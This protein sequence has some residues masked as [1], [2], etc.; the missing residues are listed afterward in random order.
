MLYLIRK[1]A[2]RA[3]LLA[4]R[5]S[6]ANRVA[7]V[8]H[9]ISHLFQILICMHQHW[10][11]TPTSSAA[12]SNRSGKPTFWGRSEE[13]DVHT[14][15]LCDFG[16]AAIERHERQ[17][18]AFGEGNIDRILSRAA[19]A[20]RHLN[21]IIDQRL[22]RMP[23]DPRRTEMAIRFAGMFGQEI[24]APRRPEQS[25]CHFELQRIWRDERLTPGEQAPRCRGALFQNK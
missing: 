22:D 10:R 17:T 1:L 8:R 11:L 21:R 12:E 25:V 15:G 7:G 4:L 14:R 2:S 16:H 20:R 23:R 6:G 19:E 5:L 3:P 9:E 18:Q 24:A 13:T